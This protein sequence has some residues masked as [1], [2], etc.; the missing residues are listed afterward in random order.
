M[1]IW[2]G[3][4]GIFWGCIVML[5]CACGNKDKNESSLLHS[6]ASVSV[7]P[8]QESW[9]SEL[10]LSLEGKPQALVRYG[11]MERYENQQ[12][13][14]FDQG[15]EIDFFDVNGRHVSRLACERGEY[16]EIT[17]EMK[18]MGRVV[19]VSDTGITLR[20][21]F[22]KWDPRIGKIVSDSAVVVTT[23]HH[24]TLY[25]TGFESTSDLRNWVIR[26]PTGITKRH[27]DI[28]AFEAEWIEASPVDTVFQNRSTEQ[29]P[30]L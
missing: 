24:D 20:T 26:K 17:E 7:I 10:T 16:N 1:K 18:G 30:G 21:P 4:I 19:V 11:H 13:V 22:L 15:V 29:N 23:I 6:S 9:Y 14:F 5:L 3:K 27:V 2:L 25:G 28:Q 12:K 8:D